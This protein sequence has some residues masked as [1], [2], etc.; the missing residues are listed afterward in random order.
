MHRF[1]IQNDR[2]SNNFKC[3]ELT[4]NFADAGPA[5]I[6]ITGASGDAA[7]GN[8]D[9]NKIEGAY[10]GDLNVCYITGTA[11]DSKA[12]FDIPESNVEVVRIMNRRDCCGKSIDR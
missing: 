1:I 6:D 8:Q 12:Q 9:Q 10:D 7:W 4:P 2:S 5:K 3:H 11:R